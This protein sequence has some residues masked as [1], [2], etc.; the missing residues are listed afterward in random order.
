VAGDL[1]QSAFP[2]IPLVKGL[3]LEC[4]PN[5]D[6]LS[7]GPIY[8]LGPVGAL[9]SVFRGTLRYDR[10]FSINQCTDGMNRYK[11]FSSLMRGFQMAGVLD[12]QSSINLNSRGGWRSFL[13]QCLSQVHQ[14]PI[15]NDER[16]LRT[17]LRKL[18][19]QS[20]VTDL[21][22]AAEWYANHHYGFYIL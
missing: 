4:L 20:E 6:S 17:A 18:M 2:D 19:T 16:N 3:S 22:E 15:K 13:A 8:G 5:R 1:L 12:L 14:S 7:Y 10:I 11:G 21:L 9:E